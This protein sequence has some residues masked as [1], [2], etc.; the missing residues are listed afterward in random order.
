M[1]LDAGP[2]ADPNLGALAREVRRT[3]LAV[4]KLANRL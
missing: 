1:A 3:H 2:N 4:S